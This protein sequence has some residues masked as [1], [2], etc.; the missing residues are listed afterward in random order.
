MGAN[1][2][3]LFQAAAGSEEGTWRRLDAQ[4]FAVA[5]GGYEGRFVL[6]GP[7]TAS[8]TLAGTTVE[9]TRVEPKD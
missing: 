5:V 9:L 4:S 8:L 3:L 2:R 7:G 1:G 6:F